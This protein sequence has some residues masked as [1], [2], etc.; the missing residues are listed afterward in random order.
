MHAV[1]MTEQG[2][3]ELPAELRARLGLKG[4]QQFEAVARGRVVLLVPLLE[5]SEL[6]GSARG[7]PTDDYRDHER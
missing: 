4:G 1:R 5:A 6:R 2:T 3:V 7:A